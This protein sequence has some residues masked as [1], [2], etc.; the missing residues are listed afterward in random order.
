MRRQMSRRGFLRESG[1]AVLSLA[2]VG[3]SRKRAQ[4]E[5]VPGRPNVII[6]MTDDQGYGDFGV[7]GNPVI[8]TPH[9][10]AMAKRS[11]RMNNFYVSPV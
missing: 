6:I 5:T 3:I 8:Q 9:I 11:A 4:G 7:T 1:L 2:T 10:D